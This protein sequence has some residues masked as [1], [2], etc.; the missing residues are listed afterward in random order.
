MRTVRRFR[1]DIPEIP[2][3]RRFVADVLQRS[4]IPVTDS[5]LLVASELV[6][7]AVRHGHG[8]VELRVDLDG[9]HVRLEVLDDGHV[10]VRVPRQVPA[11]TA[12]GGRGLQ[13]VRDVS[14]RWGSGFD[15][16]GRTLVWAELAT[17]D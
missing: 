12:V 2:R 7:N 16:G 9:D 11:P 14:K 1:R 3:S 15:P 17:A 6:T 10:A 5:V 8:E 4:G 13:L